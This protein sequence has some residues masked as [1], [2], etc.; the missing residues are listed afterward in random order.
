MPR[1]AAELE[2]VAKLMEARE[3]AGPNLSGVMEVDSRWPLPFY[4]MD[5]T[6]ENDSSRRDG[7]VSPLTAQ[8]ER[9]LMEVWGISEAEWIELMTREEIK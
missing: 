2:A 8:E 5:G 7:K 6:L 9:D 3:H 4:N 1:N